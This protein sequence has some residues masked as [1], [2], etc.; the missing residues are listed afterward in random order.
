MWENMNFCFFE[1]PGSP[2]ISGVP[3]LQSYISGA[4]FWLSEPLLAEKLLTA[5]HNLGNKKYGTFPTRH[6][7]NNLISGR[8]LI[9]LQ[10]TVFCLMIFFVKLLRWCE[11]NYFARCGFQQFFMLIL[12]A[13]SQAPFMV[14][15]H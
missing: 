8:F 5:F 13:N 7:P 3:G 6:F 4:I 1:L 12:S 11:L 9:W 15:L 10:K 14:H 2:D